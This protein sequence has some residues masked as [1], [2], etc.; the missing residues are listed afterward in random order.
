M[1]EIKLMSSKRKIWEESDRLKRSK[2]NPKSTQRKEL[3]NQI[4]K[5]KQLN[6]V[7]IVTNSIQHQEIK[8]HKKSKSLRKMNRIHKIVLKGEKKIN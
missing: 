8:N 4:E 7:R 3:Q 5:V 2:D 1:F 6:K